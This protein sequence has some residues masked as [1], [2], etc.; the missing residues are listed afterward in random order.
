MTKSLSRR[1]ILKSLAVAVPAGSVLDL[2]PLQAAEHAHKA[3]RQE[4]AASPT[5]EYKPKYF[6]AHEYET[7]RSLCQM[8]I[9]ADA[10]CGGAIEAG[11]P[12][13]IDLITSEN[14]QYQARLGGGLI[15][16]DATCQQRFGKVYLRSL[17]LQQKEVLDLIAHR[18][19]EAADPTMHTAIQFFSL[20]RNLA[21]D[22]FFTSEIGI[23]Y[24]GYIGNEFLDEFPG[25]PPV[26]EV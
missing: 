22:G 10:E 8:I 14:D 24:L 4:K 21:A 26:P 25:C 18:R 7:L 2:I 12:E 9:P 20:L 3:V 17:P 15:W 23:K 1:D 11:A 16:L 19:N 13:F 5:G 6:T